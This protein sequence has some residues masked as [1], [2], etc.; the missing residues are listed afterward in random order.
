MNSSNIQRAQAMLSQ[1]KTQ[2][3]VAEA[4]GLSVSTLK[5]GL[6]GE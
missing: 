2:A 1:G 6:K 4:L 3:E 5:K